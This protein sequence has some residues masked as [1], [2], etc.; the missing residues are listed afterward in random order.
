MLPRDAIAASII[1]LDQVSG[2]AMGVF[3]A[4]QVGG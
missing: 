3:C 2:R 4:N 1:S